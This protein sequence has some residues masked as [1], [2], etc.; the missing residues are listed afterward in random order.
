MLQDT[1][2]LYRYEINIPKEKLACKGKECEARGGYW[3]KEQAHKEN[4][5]DKELYMKNH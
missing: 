1:W 5:N 3:Q 2:L 4:E